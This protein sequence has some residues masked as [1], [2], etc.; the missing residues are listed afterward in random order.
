MAA[1]AAFEEDGEGGDEEGDEG[2][3]EGTLGRELVKEVLGGV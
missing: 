1:A 3:G 2:E